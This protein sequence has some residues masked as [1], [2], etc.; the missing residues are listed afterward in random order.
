MEMKSLSSPVRR[1]SEA[2]M[3]LIETAI[4][5]LILFIA[6]A[7][8]MG[9]GTVATIATENQGHL[10]ARSTEYA[11]DKMEQLLSLAYGDPSSDT[12][13]SSCIQYLTTQNCAAGGSGLTPGGATINSTTHAVDFDTPVNNYV[14]YLDK[15]GKPLGGGT[16]PPGTWYYMRVWNITENAGLNLKTIT[17]ACRVRFV[18]GGPNART[19]ADAVLVSYKSKPF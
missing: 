3:T 17:V 18:V 2:G 10:G 12:I 9:L 6:T 15:D 5:L 16:T 13:S 7:G 8:L 14:D 11:Q 19:L 4:A 1:G